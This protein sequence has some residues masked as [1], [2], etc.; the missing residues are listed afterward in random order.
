M[1]PCSPPRSPSSYGRRTCVVGRARASAMYVL[2]DGKRCD[3][4]ALRHRRDGYEFDMAR[5]R[6][7]WA[8]R[9][10]NATTGALGSLPAIAGAVL[11]ILVWAVSGPLFAFSDTWQLMI[12]T[13]T[14]LVTF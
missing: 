6:A 1:S 7:P 11:I 14:T 3:C 10:T 13:F 4:S 2:C 9:A 12:N 8:V 5:E